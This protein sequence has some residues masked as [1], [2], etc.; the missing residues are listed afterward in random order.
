[1]P[2]SM[3]Q[4]HIYMKGNDSPYPR[5]VSSSY[6]SATCMLAR[7]TLPRGKQN[8]QERVGKPACTSAVHSPRLP[9]RMVGSRGRR[10]PRSLQP[11]HLFLVH[12]DRRPIPH[13]SSL[14]QAPQV[15]DSLLAWSSRLLS[16]SPPTLSSQHCLLLESKNED[17]AEQRSHWATPGVAVIMHGAQ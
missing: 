11:T 10:V 1:M 13:V 9:G 7:S 15:N 16:R 2:G 6:T 8:I 5:P 14:N 4:L 12:E 17:W 3:S